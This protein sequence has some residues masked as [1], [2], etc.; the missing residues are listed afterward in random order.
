MNWPSALRRGVPK[1]ALQLPSPTR[2]ARS[3]GRGSLLQPSHPQ[4]GGVR[5]PPPARPQTA[6]TGGSSS[7]SS[8]SDLGERPGTR[9]WSESTRPPRDMPEVS[10]GRAGERRRSGP[11]VEHDDA[12]VL[13]HAAEARDEVT[14][15]PRIGVEPP[16]RR[17][18]EDHEALSRL[19]RTFDLVTR[20]STVGWAPRV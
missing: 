13:Q 11:Q 16:E 19:T 1:L 4:R 17:P 7:L 8:C 14:L 3:R 15:E 2:P 6:P 9:H 18:G 10:R 20:G 5:S 12:V